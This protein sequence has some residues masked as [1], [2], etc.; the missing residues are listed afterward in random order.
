[1]SEQTPSTSDAESLKSS[2]VDDDSKES[3]LSPYSNLQI[4]ESHS[5]PPLEEICSRA[6]TPDYS[7]LIYA[8]NNDITSLTVNSAPSSPIQASTVGD[9]PTVCSKPV[10]NTSRSDQL[11]KDPSTKIHL[12]ASSP[13]TESLTTLVDDGMDYENDDQPLDQLETIKPA[14]VTTPGTRPETDKQPD[15]SP[16]FKK[17]LEHARIIAQVDVCIPSKPKVVRNETHSSRTQLVQAPTR[18]PTRPTPIRTAHTPTARTT[19]SPTKSPGGTPRIVG[20]VVASASVTKTPSPQK[21]S[22]LVHSIPVT[23]PAPVTTA[24][25]P[26]P[27]KPINANNAVIRSPVPKVASPPLASGPS[28]A[29]VSPQ[30]VDASKR[31]KQFKAI[32]MFGRNIISSCVVKNKLK[33]P[34]PGGPVQVS[35]TPSP[36]SQLNDSVSP[37]ANVPPHADEASIPT[38]NAVTSIIRPSPSGAP[39]S[40]I[41]KNPTHQTAHPQ[42]K[43]PAP[44]M[45]PN[46]PPPPPPQQA[47]TIV[48]QHHPHTVSNDDQPIRHI[49]P[50]QRIPSNPSHARPKVVHQKYPPPTPVEGLHGGQ[51]KW[52]AIKTIKMANGETCGI[53]V[54]SPSVFT[55]V[56]IPNAK[57]REV[58]QQIAMQEAKK[59]RNRDYRVNKPT[60]H[61]NNHPMLN[62]DKSKT[63]TVPINPRPVEQIERIKHPVP[64]LPAPPAPTPTNTSP[65]AAKTPTKPLSQNFLSRY[66]GKVVGTAKL[67]KNDLIRTPEFRSPKNSTSSTNSGKND[68]HD[69]VCILKHTFSIYQ[70]STVHDRIFLCNIVL[71]G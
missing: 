13:E 15:K 63:I 38:V 14:V 71:I 12:V 27:V 37:K 19:H 9:T 23:P 4:S 20:P 70:F 61:G 41:H 68:F 24:I 2:V 6:S 26:I 25:S 64:S 62:N 60:Y 46:R 39:V 22:G 11:A 44:A 5:P 32:N 18:T 49:I 59:K 17:S 29:H 40:V 1:M 51:S 45:R 47:E 50:P 69:K 57:L 56:N 30:A 53:K 55:K 42:P 31:P 7:A 65:T 21:Q 58:K 54:Q 33:L 10:Q 8:Q 52:P 66:A 43:L 3:P 36:T 28:P 16:K 67:S 48:V 35:T 34:K